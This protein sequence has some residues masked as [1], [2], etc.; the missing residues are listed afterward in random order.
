MTRLRGAV[1]LV[2]LLATILHSYVGLPVFAAIAL[3]LVVVGVVW[4]W[5]GRNV[6]R[7]D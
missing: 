4:H 5:L 1:V 6:S 2:V 3:P 7:L